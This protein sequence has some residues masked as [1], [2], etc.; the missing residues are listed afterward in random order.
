MNKYNINIH[1]GNTS[2]NKK[3]KIQQKALNSK[4]YIVLFVKIFYFL[5]LQIIGKQYRI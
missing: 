2:N 4:Q 3:L 5:R 1:I